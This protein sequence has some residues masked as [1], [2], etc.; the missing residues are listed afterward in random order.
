MF[1]KGLLGKW[2][3]GT[4]KLYMLFVKRI[5]GTA[6][7]ESRIIFKGVFMFKEI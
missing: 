2:F 7:Y 3:L 6:N 1:R 4:Q 5:R